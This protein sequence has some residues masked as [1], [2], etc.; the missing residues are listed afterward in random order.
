MYLRAY[1]PTSDLGQVDVQGC[2]CG[3][4][5]SYA[6]FNPHLQR[7][8]PM[9]SNHSHAGVCA[10]ISPGAKAGGPHAATQAERDDCRQTQLDAALPF[11]C[12]VVKVC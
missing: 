8:L 9:V 7:S 12:L 6:S 2:V 3:V 11:G 4:M 1:V 5:R 10:L